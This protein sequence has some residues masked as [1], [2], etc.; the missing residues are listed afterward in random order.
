[1]YFGNFEDKQDICNQFAIPNFEGTVVFAAYDTPDYDGYA[2]VVYVQGGKFYMASG[3]HCS[4]YGLEGQWDPI[5][6]PIDGL[7]KIIGE[8]TGMLSHYHAEFER[9][10]VEL[11]SRIGVKD[12]L[13]GM[14]RVSPDTL[15]V[16]LRVAY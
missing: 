2:E 10:F 7:R 4:C 8:G 16:L 6:M 12:G 11:L 13:D 14:E 9:A 3:S 1:M 5:E 15:S